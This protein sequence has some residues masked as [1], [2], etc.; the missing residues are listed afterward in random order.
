MPICVREVA[1]E[2]S[3]AGLN[4]CLCFLCVRSAY[5]CTSMHIRGMLNS[6]DDF[7]RLNS[8]MPGTSKPAAPLAFPGRG[9]TN[10]DHVGEERLGH[11]SLELL[12]NS[13]SPDGCELHSANKWPMLERRHPMGHL[14]W[15]WEN[16]TVWVTD[17]NTGNNYYEFYLRGYGANITSSGCVKGGS[18]YG[19]VYQTANVVCCTPPPPCTGCG[20]C[21]GCQP[22]GCS[23][24]IVVDVFDEGMHLTSLMDGVSF[25]FNGNSKPLYMSW[26]DPSYHNAWL[27][28][29]RDHNGTI[30]NV[31]ELFGYPTQPQI[32]TPDGKRNGWLALAVYDDPSYGGNGD[33]VIDT[34]DAI[35]SSLLLWIDENH[36]GI[37]QPQE[38]HHLQEMGATK[39]DLRYKANKS[40][41]DAFGNTF[42]F[43]GFVTV[44]TQGTN[45]EWEERSRQAWDVVLNASETSPGGPQPNQFCSLIPKYP[46]SFDLG[47]DADWGAS[48]GPFTLCALLGE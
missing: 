45:G 40:Y 29:D 46:R 33:G 35:Y 9:Y 36:D 47:L 22:E 42:Q 27:A 3:D 43:E 15:H 16:Q 5:L 14:P 28:L 26:T 38:L 23:S 31:N 13:S 7:S 1:N 8:G 39:I 30:N 12:R 37:S 48:A 32:A 24:P 11:P 19:Q 17:G 44:N 21:R 2:N 6:R 34:K 25:D 20:T 4:L 18:Y 41:K 10:L